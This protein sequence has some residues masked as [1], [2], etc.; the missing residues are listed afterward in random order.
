MAEKILVVDDDLDTLRLVGLML[1][2][3]GY[4]IVVAS[5]GQQALA[6]AKSEQPDLIMLD[7][8]MPGLDGV[9]VARRLRVDPDT[10]EIMIIM[11]TAKAQA[12]DKVTG[13]DAGADDYLTK[14]TQPAELIAHVKAVLKRSRRTQAAAA[15]TMS[16]RGRMIAILAVKGGLG[17][18]TLALNL[19]IVLREQFKK[20]VIVADYRPG[21]GTIG[22]DL[23]YDN[24]QGLVNL[25]TM[26]PGDITPQ[27]IESQMVIHST[28]VRF[29]LS[30]PDPQDSRY[31]SEVE[32]FD[33]LTQKLAYM[34]PFIILDLGVSLTPVNGKVL[35]ACDQIILPIEPVG[36]TILQTKA[37]IG[38]LNQKGIGDQRLLTVLINRT[39]M[40]I[41]LSLGQVQDQLG[42]MVTV[43][44]PP[45]LELFY[46]ASVRHTPLVLMQPD[47][48]AAQQFT[49]LADKVVKWGK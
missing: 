29:L 21:C 49:N 33:A 34:A 26:K 32:N 12:E 16:E 23:G 11:F 31:Q 46:Q 9:E 27:E 13:F 43:I 8:M 24:S 17:V 6:L 38:F 47:G 44:F 42:R 45:S 28:G 30:S 20:E 2:R 19:G 36:H 40:G 37:L 4:K 39:R 41:Q 5:S 14:P 48:I 1:E 7:V 35:D 3:Q 10:Q 15:K 25:L 22:L 18:S